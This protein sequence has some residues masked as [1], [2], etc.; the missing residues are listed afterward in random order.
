MFADIDAL[1]VYLSECSRKSKTV[2]ELETAR[3]GQPNGS[4]EKKGF[5]KMR[6]HKTQENAKKPKGTIIML[7]HLMTNNNKADNT[8]KQKK[9]SDNRV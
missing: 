5:K 7:Q 2:S 9:N 8:S 1:N 6:R 4:G 3:W